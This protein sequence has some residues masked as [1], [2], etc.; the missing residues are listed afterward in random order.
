MIAERM[1]NGDTRSG[2][3]SSRVRC[4]RSMTS[5]PPMPLPMTTPTREELTSSIRS[6]LCSI[7]IVVAA[8]AN[9]MKRAHF[10]TSFLSIQFNGSKPGTSPANRVEW[11]AA[12]KSVIGPMPDR[13]A[14]T[15]SHVAAV[16][17]PSGETNPMPVTTTRLRIRPRSGCCPTTLCGDSGQ[18]LLPGCAGERLPPD[19][20]EHHTGEQAENPRD[21]ERQLIAAGHR[22]D[23]A[24][25]ERRHRR[26][27][28]VAGADPPVDH[29]RVLAAEGL[30]GQ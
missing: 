28:L 7:A 6:P 23:R 3:R 14:H 30:A 9:W 5:N 12:S 2:P 8:I 15:P 21:P 4:S 20:E 24:G 17:M 10:F 27:E 1:K 25:P 13:P 22:A 19:G 16:P 11:R 18:R 26:A 29:A